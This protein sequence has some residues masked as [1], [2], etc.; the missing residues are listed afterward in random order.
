[1]TSPL[2]DIRDLR[3]TYATDRGEMQALR[4]VNL[5]AMPGEVV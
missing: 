1:M 2:L 3:L 4:G 5:Q